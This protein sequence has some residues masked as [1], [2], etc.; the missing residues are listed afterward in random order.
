M[1]QVGPRQLPAGQS[2]VVM[3][4]GMGNGVRMGMACAP[5]HITAV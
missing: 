3:G 2:S 1:A 5:V 4:N